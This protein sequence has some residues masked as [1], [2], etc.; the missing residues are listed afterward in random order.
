LYN[1]VA[2]SN[3]DQR[4]MLNRRR[5]RND[6]WTARNKL[7]KRNLGCK[8]KNLKR[9]L[10]HHVKIKMNKFWIWFK[11]EKEFAHS[12]KCMQEEIVDLI[13]IPLRRFI[14]NGMMMQVVNKEKHIQCHKLQCSSLKASK[15]D[16]II[17]KRKIIRKSIS[18]LKSLVWLI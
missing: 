11:E 15:W 9:K 2:L 6:K 17:K 1:N 8:K 14:H 18:C 10:N 7:A 5:K 16:I 4:K 12:A 3:A 13:I